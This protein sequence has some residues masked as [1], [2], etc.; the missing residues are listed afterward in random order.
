ML[1]SGQNFSITKGNNSKVMQKRVM[2]LVH[3]IDLPMKSPYSFVLFMYE[4]YTSPHRDLLVLISLTVFVLCSG[5]KFKFKIAKGNNSKIMQKRVMVLVH[6]IDLPM[7]S[8]YS[9]VLLMYEHCTSP[10]RDLLVLIPLTAFVLCSG[11]KFKYKIAKGNNS[12]IMQK[13][14]MVLVHCTS[15]HQ[16]LSNNEVWG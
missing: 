3:C 1:F 7:K 11:H 9:F 12:K 10:H 4:H 5:H 6:C 2:V 14:V 16:D 13:R 8:P 15:S